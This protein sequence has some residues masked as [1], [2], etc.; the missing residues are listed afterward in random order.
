MICVNA[1]KHLNQLLLSKQ[2]LAFSNQHRA[3]A[4]LLIIIYNNT[5]PIDYITNTSIFS[6]YNTS[7]ACLNKKHNEFAFTI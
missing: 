5:G 7:K 4:V 6:M 3:Y 2:M 1:E